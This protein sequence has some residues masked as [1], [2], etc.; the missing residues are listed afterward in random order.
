MKS[1]PPN[2]IT[3]FASNRAFTLVEVSLALGVASFCLLSI[4][5][6]LPV[7]L[8]SNQASIEQTMAVNISSAIV[9]DLRT[10]QPMGAKLEPPVRPAHPAG[11]SGRL[12]A[13]RLPRI[14]WHRHRRG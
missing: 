11:G 1:E 4:V 5:G 7:G 10:A 12:H 2:S 14:R 6:L 13:H 3:K 8:T 9:S